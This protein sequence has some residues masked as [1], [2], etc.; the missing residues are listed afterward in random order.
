MS[1]RSSAAHPPDAPE[2]RIPSARAFAAAHKRTARENA[3][4]E[5]HIALYKATTQ[6]MDAAAAVLK[7]ADLSTPQYNVLRI[8]RGAGPEGATCGQVIER[9]I[10]RDPDV[11]RLLDRL[12]TRGLIVRGRDARDRRIV[13]THLTEA[14]LELVNSLDEPVDALH[15]RHFG[16]L[17]ERQL[18]E[19]CKL[20][21]RLKG[22]DG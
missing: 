19:I 10:A 5:A 16:H 14:G 9:M 13:R 11:T 20:A 22:V 2:T 7:P 15:Q 3:N 4:A 6:L 12:A 17:S 18:A 1:R 21:E 8:L